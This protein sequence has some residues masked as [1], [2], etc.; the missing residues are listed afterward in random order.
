MI[1][2]EH[3]MLRYRLTHPEI[4]AALASA[5]HGS[6]VLIADGHYPFATASGPNATL[7]F[8]NLR[9]GVVTVPEVL[10]LV[11]EAVP[12][13]SAAV[14][15]PPKEPDQ[16]VPQIFADFGRLLGSATPLEELDRFAFY[17]AAKS[18][19]VALVIA[20]GEQRTYANILLTIGVA[21]AA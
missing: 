7:V 5:G 9:A 12:I 21:T 4:L 8:L 1:E 10:E 6:R 20:T 14:M 16:P 11:A 17:D 18:E 19:D 15:H 3:P 13:E 2:R